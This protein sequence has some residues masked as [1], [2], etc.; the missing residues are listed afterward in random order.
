M[1]LRGREYTKG[2]R[3]KIFIV[4]FFIVLS[5]SS[6]SQEL[7]FNFINP[8]FIGGNFYNAQWLLASAQAQ[9]NL[10]ESG[11]S[12]RYTQ[13]PLADFEENIKRQIL[14]QLTRQLMADTFGEDEL[15]EGKYE[16]GD[17]IIEITPGA[18]GV[19]IQI[20]DSSTGGETTVIVP[21]F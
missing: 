12:D 18:D 8:S 1:I 16:I 5:T 19:N 6:Y 7:V 14:S 11:S 20:F 9:N 3:M 4:L 10:N 21:Y 17:F 15:K 13:D 2:G